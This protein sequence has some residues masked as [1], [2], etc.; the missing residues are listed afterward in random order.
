M[1]K[2]EFRRM[3]GRTKE[4]F[5]QDIKSAHSNE[6]DIVERFVI[7][8]NDNYDQN[9]TI[10]D[11]GVNNDGDFLSYEEVDTRADYRVDGQLIEVKYLEDHLTFFRLKVTQLK[12]YIRQGAYLLLANGYKTSDPKFT[13][14]KT[15]QLKDLLKNGHQYIFPMWEGK[16][17]VEVYAKNYK[18]FDL[19]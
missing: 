6:R 8:F 9:L 5:E 2:G 18:W 14:L 15:D 3:A 19:P 11:N 7:Y 1:H 4:Q 16:R 17:V 10:E 13:L 12:S